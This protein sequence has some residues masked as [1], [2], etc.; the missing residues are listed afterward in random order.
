MALTIGIVGLPNVGKST[1]FNALTRAEVLAANY[2][3]AT[4]DPNVGVVPLPDPRLNRLAE[5]FGSEKILPATVSFVDIAGIVK[6]ASEG[7]GLGNKFLANIR[8]ADAICQ[9]TRAFSDPDVTRVEGSK[10]PAGDMDTI[11]T[12]LI[13][14]DLQTLENARPRIE[15]E[16]KRKAVEPDVLA[17]MDQAKELLEGGT[18]LFQ[19]AEK[20][21]ID[22]DQLKELQL[23]TAKPFIYVFNTDEDGLADE[24][25]QSKMRELVAPAEAIFLDAKFEAELI[26]LD[27]EE[28]AEMLESTGQ[29]EPGLDKLAR[30][31]FDT[32]GL[33]TYLTAGPKEARAWTIRKG[34]TAPEA[35]G[36][37]HT[38]FQKGFI[39]AEIVSFEDLDELG[40]MAEAKAAGKVRM[41]GKDYVMADG[42]V[43]EFRFNV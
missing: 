17:A 18:T 23:M 37:I 14:A 7:E 34:W 32:L 9:V 43:V 15:K 8:E 33:Q 5:I 31:G 27:P 12:E 24:A 40:S 25:M 30:V 35:A 13:L 36:V 41:E 10:D 6:G 29:D 3:F 28:A 16:V 20:A 21:G 11:S 22:V 39:K 4:I 26:E 42:D 2:P 19:G 1:M 38:D